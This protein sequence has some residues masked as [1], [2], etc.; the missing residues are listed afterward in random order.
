M[1]SPSKCSCTWLYLRVPSQQRRVRYKLFALKE[2]KLC[3]DS[4]LRSRGMCR[5]RPRPRGGVPPPQRSLPS[6]EY[7]AGLSEFISEHCP[8]NT[9]ADRGRQRDEQQSSTRVF[10]SGTKW[11]LVFGGLHI[12]QQPRSKYM[13]SS[14]SCE[15]ERHRAAEAAGIFDSPH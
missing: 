12:K 14:W 8:C 7:P 5:P 9:G 4:S 11:W 3:L 13:C 1:M 15:G 6:S 10:L 2:H